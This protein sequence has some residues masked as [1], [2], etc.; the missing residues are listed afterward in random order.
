MRKSVRLAICQKTNLKQLL[1]GFW[2]CPL[3]LCLFTSSLKLNCRCV[4][5]ERVVKKLWLTELF[6]NGFF[7]LYLY[8]NYYS[9]LKSF[10]LISH[11]VCDLSSGQN[12][13]HKSQQ[14]WNQAYENLK[15]RK[16]RELVVKERNSDLFAEIRKSCKISQYAG[17]V[18]YTRQ[19]DGIFRL[20][21]L[22]GNLTQIPC[23][24][25]TVALI[26]N[27]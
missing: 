23:V 26:R 12:W 25:E 9:K 2:F 6:S 4:S 17:Y 19:K 8:A 20:Q 22:A 5:E 15:E 18:F 3:F 21:R 1:S 24:D 11:K 16:R 14:W 27:I 7:F 13:R 10:F